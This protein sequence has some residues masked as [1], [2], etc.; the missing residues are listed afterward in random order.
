MANRLVANPALVDGFVGTL[1]ACIRR[2]AYAVRGVVE[3]GMHRKHA[4]NQ[5][6][7]ELVVGREPASP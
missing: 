6:I 1:V 4:K 7:T 5:H 2:K 3:A